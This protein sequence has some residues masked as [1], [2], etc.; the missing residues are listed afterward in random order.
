MANILLTSYCNRNC[1][2]CFGRGKVDLN[3]EKGDPSKNLSMAALEK[4]IAF[5]KKSLLRRFVLL[6]GEPTLHPDF[7]DLMDRVFTE[8]SFK[9]IL[10]FTNGVIPDSALAYLA[11]QADPRLSV[12]M[13]LNK[14]GDYPPEQ[15][16]RIETVLKT[17]GAKIGLGINIYR[18]GQSY[19]YLVDAIESYGLVRHIRLGLTQPIVGTNNR[20]AKREE[21]PAIAEDIVAFADVVRHKKISFSFDCGFEFCMFSLD[22]HKE[23]LRCG[24]KFSSQCNPIIDI[25]PDLKIW[26]C[27]PLM[28]D[29]CGNLDEFDTRHDIID[30]YNEKYKHIKRMGNLSECAQC[31]YRANGLCGGGCLARTLLSFNHG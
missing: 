24:I 1:A 22:Q 30:Y 12:A 31:C 3:K 15:Q 25:G 20:Y 13:N 8:P 18:A 4:I 6:G 19:D 27:F 21:F 23:L 9:S 7:T 29:P 17:I 11:G 10:V 14:P 2:Y 16:S 5:Y 28:Q 26:R